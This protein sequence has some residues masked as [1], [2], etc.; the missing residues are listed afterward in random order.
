V[1]LRRAILGIGTLLSLGILEACSHSKALCPDL[2]EVK[3]RFEPP[4]SEPERRWVCGDPKSPPYERI[5]RYQ[6]GVHMQAFLQQ[7]GYVRARTQVKGDRLEVHPGEATKARSI[8]LSPE[9]PELQKQLEDYLGEAVTPVL[10][11]ALEKA[12]LRSLREAG[13]PCATVT[14]RS[15]DADIEVSINR[16]SKR[17]FGHLQLDEIKGVYPEALRRFRPFEP[18]DVFD[19]RGLELYERRL[20]R[21]E[22]IQ[23]TYFQESCAQPAAEA[24]FIRQS[25]LVGLPRTL[26]FGLGVTTE[27]GPILQ[28]SWRH[29]RF[30]AM[31]SPVLSSANLSYREQSLASTAD[32]YLWR[33]FEWFSLSPSWRLTRTYTSEVT[34][35][36]NLLS[37]DAKHLWDLS[38]LRLT[39][40]A[41][42]AFSVE[43][44]KT[45][46]NPAYSRVSSAALRFWADLRSHAFEW[47]N[48]HPQDG[49]QLKLDVDYRDPRFGFL[50]RFLRTQADARV[51][52][53]M[54]VCGDGRCVVGLR[55]AL[56]SAWADELSLVRVPPSLKSFLG[57]YGNLRGYGL[58]SLPRNEGQGS[59]SSVVAGAELRG[60]SL[61]APSWE[62][63]VF[64]DAGRAGSVALQLEDEIYW[65][66][67]LGLRWLSPLGLIQGYLSRNAESDFYFYA[68]LGGEF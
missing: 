21:Q 13:Y 59:L 3:G 39:L 56:S 51:L 31:A 2:V 14:S 18:E 29:H 26:R 42:P 67:G 8:K 10:L 65:A 33:G 46:L 54:G 22:L 6:A 53:D 50:D 15:Y 23:G 19:V 60:V 9:D 64:F 52:R 11:N 16:G 63:Y 66:S 49:W 38:G 44:F 57:G 36:E 40:A 37:L 5:P 41:G 12:T 34:G 68:G 45:D 28:G 7:R 47:F 35:I 43:W 4:L 30:A 61:F 1:G 58:R 25:F 17:V 48:A 24:D 55:A 20:S 32:L 27:A 62:P